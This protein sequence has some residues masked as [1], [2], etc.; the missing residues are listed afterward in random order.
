MTK[1][2]LKITAEPN[3]EENMP[4]QKSELRF[5]LS[6]EWRDRRLDNRIVRL[7]FKTLEDAYKVEHPKE[8]SGILHPQWIRRDLLG[9]PKRWEDNGLT[10]VVPKE[11]LNR[12]MEECF[13]F[14]IDF[15]V[16]F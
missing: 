9:M 4:D 13:S 1:G 7:K 14:E 15:S 8:V 6:S 10:L 3:K 5:G 2:S 16:I 12:I 11:A